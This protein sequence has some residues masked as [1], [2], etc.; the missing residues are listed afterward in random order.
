METLAPF[1]KASA[2]LAQQ[3]AAIDDD[4]AEPDLV[5][6][7]TV[8]ASWL[9]A[10]RMGRAFIAGGRFADIYT[11]EWLAYLRPRFE[12]DLIDR[13]VI[14]A[15]SDFDLALVISKDRSLTQK[16]ATLVYHLD[17]DGI[18]YFSRYGNELTNWAI[19]EDFDLK[20]QA[21]SEIQSDDPDFREA[22]ARLNLVFDPH[23]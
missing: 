22:L 9:T 13:G 20:D 5:L 15:G 12:V 18:H 1:R 16:I 6:G 11:S 3:L 19:F 21:S 8:P 2:Q 17:Y 10:R 7:G 14:E 4:K 23:H